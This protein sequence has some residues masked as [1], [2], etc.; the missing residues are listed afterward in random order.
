MKKYVLYSWH[1]DNGE[2]GIGVCYTKDFTTNIGYYGCTGYHN[3][4]S[5]FFGWF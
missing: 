4:P 3:C 1:S 2:G 5:R